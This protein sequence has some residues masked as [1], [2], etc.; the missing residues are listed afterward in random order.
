MSQYS[1]IF[2]SITTFK[3]KNIKN[4]IRCP[5]C[6]L[7]PFISIDNKITNPILYLQCENKH[8]IN[9][10]IEKLYENNKNYQIDSVKCQKCNENNISNLYYC[11]KC[12]GFFCEKEKHFLVKEHQEIPFEKIDCCCREKGHIN[13]NVLYYCQTHKKN[14]C[15]YCKQDKH[16]CDEIKEF[17]YIK[18]EQFKMIKNNLSN[19]E[20]KLIN[21]TNNIDS[22][23]SYLQTLIEQIRNEF[24][25]YKEKNQL[26]IKIGND[27]IDRYE[28]KK[29]KNCLNYQIIQNTK[30]IT[31]NNI[32]FIFEQ[33]KF[34]DIK[35][36]LLTQFNTNFIDI[37][38]SESFIE[39]NK[40]KIKSQRDSNSNSFSERNSSSSSLNHNP[41]YELREI[42]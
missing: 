16:D 29:E 35:E 20:K 7:I 11:I 4:I 14:I 15:Q 30:N 32:D 42:Y 3:T 5:K 12:F 13:N 21:L 24:K 28:D 1:Y 2:D 31:F 36:K 27:I 26:E 25:K 41:L 40:T 19:S 22:F 17:V 38:N 10:P 33:N 39:E 8:N 34:E 6:H 9:G 37:S 18:K 23:I